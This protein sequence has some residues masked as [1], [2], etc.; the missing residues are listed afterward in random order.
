MQLHR[1][2]LH[3]RRVEKAKDGGH[4]HLAAIDVEPHQPIL[5]RRLA[6]EVLCLEQLES[7]L[8][9]VT[10]DAD[11]DHVAGDRAFQLLGSSFGDDLPVVDDG[12]A[13]A[14]RV[15]LV[16]VVRGQKDGDAALVQP[17]HLVP[18]ARS[19]L[20]VEAGSRLVEEQELRLVD[21][22]QPDVESALLA[23]RVGADLAVGAGFQLQRRDQLGRPPR[24]GGGGHAV[25]PS[26]EDEL[27]TA[28]DLA[29]GAAGLA[30]IADAFPDLVRLGAQV[31][32]R[33]ARRAF[34]GRQQSRKHSQRG[35]L[36]SAVRSQK[37][38]DLSGPHREVDPGDRLDDALAGLEGPA[39]AACLDDQLAHCGH[40]AR[41]YPWGRLV[42]PGGLLRFALDA[43]LEKVP[44]LLERGPTRRRAARGADGALHRG[45]R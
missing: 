37:S 42:Q 17:L 2:E 39:Q 15:R 1:P 4:R 22:A 16:Q 27:S 25:Q 12:D 30:H 19:A 29:I 34:G 38:E 45:D 32:T 33:H 8:L 28:G 26:L 21:K 10:S 14:E 3:P 11:R 6:D 7:S 24:C 40:H 5:A 31:D 18:D 23:A 41:H 13:V 9:L 35:R 36:S 43:E 20:R 44:E